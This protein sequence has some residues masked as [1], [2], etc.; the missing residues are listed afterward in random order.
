MNAKNTTFSGHN[1]RN[2]SRMESGQNDDTQGQTRGRKEG[3]EEIKI[4][5]ADI[6]MPLLSQSLF[7]KRKKKKASKEFACHCF[8][9]QQHV[10]LFS[11]NTTLKCG[12]RM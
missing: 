4:A 11:S 2:K 9:L 1:G 6:M 8:L 7:L 12:T 10:F 3:D 5:E